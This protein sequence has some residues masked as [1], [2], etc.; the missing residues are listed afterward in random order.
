MTK[1]YFTRRLHEALS[2]ADEASGEKERNAHLRAARYY[3]DLLGLNR[4]PSTDSEIL[5]D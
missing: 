5:A 2:L 1:A 3:C 4:L